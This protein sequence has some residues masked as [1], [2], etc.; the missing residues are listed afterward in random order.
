MSL[1]RTLNA[2]LAIKRRQHLDSDLADEIQAHLELAEKDAV[3]C[4]LSPAQARSEAL[5]RFGGIEQM[6][7][8]HRDR[9]SVRW[10]ET[11]LRDFRYGLASLLRARGFSAVVIGVLALGIGGT[12]AMFS[13]VDAA[14]L[15]PLPFPEPDR[16]VQ[17]WEAPRPGVVN[18]TTVPQFLAWKR[19][20]TVFEALA[21]EQPI[22]AALSVNGEPM[23]LA[24]DAVTSNTSRCSAR[25][26]H[27]AALS[28]RKTTGRELHRSLFSAMLPGKLTSVAIPASSA[29][30][31]SLTGSP[32]KS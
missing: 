23:R 27:S 18:A 22:L 20:G 15:K 19:L 11:L 3:A 13:V 28:P 17:L 30:A 14:L 32:F 25:R 10:L 7:E 21:A 4:G 29:G 8:E 6:K 16:I 24:G 2:L 1:R 5:C 12:V 31:L 26:L 9:R